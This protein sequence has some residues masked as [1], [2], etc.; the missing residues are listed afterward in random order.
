MSTKDISWGVKAAGVLG[1]SPWSK[2]G[3]YL[4]PTTLRPPGANS[5]I[6]GPSTSWSTKGLSRPVMG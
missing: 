2:G 5:Y 3:Q 4:E 6:L 1:I